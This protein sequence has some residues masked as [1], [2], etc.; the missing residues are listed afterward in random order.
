MAMNDVNTEFLRMRFYGRGSGKIAE[1][2]QAR[3]SDTL[4]SERTKWRSAAQ[5]VRCNTATRYGIADDAN[6]MAQLR[7]SAG[8]IAHMAK[9][10]TDRSSEYVEDFHGCAAPVRTSA[11]AHK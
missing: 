9:Q 6:L 4:Y 10:T 2:R 7:L 11:H 8:Q 5:Q 1:A 3:N